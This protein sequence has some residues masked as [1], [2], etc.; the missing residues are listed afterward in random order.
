MRKELMVFISMIVIAA[1]GYSFYYFNQYHIEDNDVSIQSNLD[2]WLN[3]PNSEE[4]NPVVLKVEK[5]GDTTSHIILFQ[6]ENGDYGYARL[7]KGLNGKF[8]IDIAAYGSGQGRGLQ[9]ASYRV[10]DTSEG[11]YMIL[12]GKNPD[13]KID[14]ILATAHTGEYDLTFNVSEDKTFFQSAK[15]PTDVVQPFPAELSFYDSDNNEIE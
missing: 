4:I 2:T 5:L 7:E 15:I 11:E 12:Y 14:H 10:I 3:R 13:L 1:S 8:K 9:N 6:L